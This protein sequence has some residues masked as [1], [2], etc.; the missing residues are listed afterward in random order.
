M[1]KKTAIQQL[2]DT[3]TSG[4]YTQYQI[5]LLATELKQAEREQI[6]DAHAAGM[7]YESCNDGSMPANQYYTKTYGE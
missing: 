6:I 7:D 1:S 4:D 3:I 2:I 5:A